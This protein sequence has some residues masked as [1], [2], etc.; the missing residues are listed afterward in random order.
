[1][2]RMS[3]SKAG[4]IRQTSGRQHRRRGD[5]DGL[6]RHVFTSLSLDPP[7][8][9]FY[10]PPRATSW[11]VADGQGNPHASLPKVGFA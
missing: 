9:T 5:A 4:V 7:L 11:S 6:L 10:R 2:A 1:M 8:A 3:I